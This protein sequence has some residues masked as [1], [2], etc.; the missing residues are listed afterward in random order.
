[1]EEVGKGP[2]WECENNKIFD[3]YSS[4]CSKFNVSTA[5]VVRK[6]SEKL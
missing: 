1:V 6:S 3:Q 5:E 2:L 4:S